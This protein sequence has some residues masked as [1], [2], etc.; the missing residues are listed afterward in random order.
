MKYVDWRERA[1]CAD[2]DPEVMFVE[3]AAQHLA[4]RICNPCPVRRECLT[5]A[6]DNRIHMGV[7]GG[8]TGR[9]R[10]ALL[11]LRPDV[12]SWHRLL[13][14]APADAW[15]SLLEAELLTGETITRE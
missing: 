13:A 5:D 4:K 3:G 11:Q 7:W 1:A 6:L 14:S 9:E 10:R 2:G 12:T 15:S 8:M